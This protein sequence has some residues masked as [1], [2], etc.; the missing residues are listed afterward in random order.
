VAQRY[1]DHLAHHPATAHRLAT[2]LARH[3]VSDNPSAGLVNTLAAVYLANGT[4][5]APVLRTIF[6]SAE[7]AAATGLKVRRPF[8]HIVASVRLLGLG[9]DA[10]AGTDGI[11]ALVYQADDAGN[12]PFGWGPPDGYPD[13]AGAW[14][15]TAVT[16]TRWNH[17]LDLVA[18]WWPDRLVRPQLGA[19][20][21]GSTPPTTHGAL[22]DTVVT[23]LF[24]WSLRAD[25]RA[26]LL[27]FLGVAATEP[28]TSSSGAVTWQLPY[29]VASLLDSP[30]HLY[31]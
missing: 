21:W 27:A 25:H 4:A 12:A 6:A 31:R 16:L 5:I 2:K 22:V 23:R 8:E 11:A 9:P 3:F 19:F 20:L 13:W 7:F 1:L 30:Y 14:S 24:G 18:G 29:W 17:T 28:V 10:A 26:A 15:S